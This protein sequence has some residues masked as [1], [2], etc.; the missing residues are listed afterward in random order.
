M[1]N[2][3]NNGVIILIM[4]HWLLK[5]KMLEVIHQIKH[6]K[7][8]NKKLKWIKVLIHF[9]KNLVKLKMNVY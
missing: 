2:G 6:K 5:R 1:L 3:G 8:K 9:I 7:L 4:T